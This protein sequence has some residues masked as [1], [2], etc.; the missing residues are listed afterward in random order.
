L[1]DPAVERAQDVV[2]GILWPAGIVGAV[3]HVGAGSAA[4]MRHARR[5]EEA[6][7]ILRPLQRAVVSTIIAIAL[8]VIASAALGRDHFVVVVDRVLRRDDGIRLSV[9]EDELSA[10]RLEP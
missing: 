2:I 3:E 5:E 9:V 1:R 7:E 10:M 8:V 6:R 4:A